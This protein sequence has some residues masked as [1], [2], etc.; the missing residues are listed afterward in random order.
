MSVLPVSHVLSR[1]RWTVIGA[2]VAAT[3]GAGGL[4][5]ASA[6]GPAAPSSFVPITPCR[7][8]DTRPASNIGP[9]STPLGPSE[10]YQ[11]PVWGT[12]GS[13]TIPAT[14]TAVGMNVTFVNPTASGFLTVF[15]AGNPPVP[16]TSNLNWVAGQQPAP[17]AVTTQLSSNGRIEFYNNAGTVDVIA[18]VVGYYE[19][20]TSGPPGPTG[21]PGAQ[22]A[23][24]P[25]G[26]TGA[27]GATGAPGSPGPQGPPLQLAP[28]D[29][30]TPFQ[31][32]N[33]AILS[34]GSTF[35]DGLNAICNDMT[36]NGMHVYE[37]F[38]TE[39]AICTAVTGNG[40]ISS[41]VNTLTLPAFVRNGSNWV[42]RST[43]GTRL[44]SI[45]CAP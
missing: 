15:P 24:G 41:G 39:I 20:A 43:A 7:L 3:I 21:A 5:S 38:P 34:C 18:D 4:L 23:P 28:V 25:T 1:S 35:N 13:C 9:R 12:N 19:P 22:G 11:A 33:G 31:I 42:L 27:P 32:V 37:D 10:I 36:L 8:M 6:A 44:S 26:P 40:V 45:G 2:A 16:W 14:A 17:N 30:F 29:Q